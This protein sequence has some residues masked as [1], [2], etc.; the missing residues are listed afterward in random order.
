[1]DARGTILVVAL[2]LHAFPVGAQSV[3]LLL[4]PMSAFQKQAFKDALAKV[5]TMPE[6]LVRDQAS[7]FVAF[8]LM[9]RGDCPQAL[10][11]MTKYLVKVADPVAL[12]GLATGAL[13]GRDPLCMRWVATR[14]E[15]ALTKAPLTDP[16]RAELRIRGQT[17]LML[18]GQATRSYKM[19]A[20]NFSDLDTVPESA[21]MRE[22]E[23]EGLTVHIS[24]G[25]APRRRETLLI[26]RLWD[27]R[28]TPLQ[29]LLAKSLEKRAA[30]E[31]KFLTSTGWI[32]VALVLLG[33]GE[34]RSAER[35]LETTGVRYINGEGLVV[36][37][38]LR[39]GDIQHTVELIARGDWVTKGKTVSRLTESWPAAFI[40]YVEQPSM[41]GTDFNA[42][43]GLISYSEALDRAGFPE[44]AERA[45][46][47]ALK[48]P[49]GDH[50]GRG[51]QAQALARLGHLEAARD[52]VREAEQRPKIEDP[53]YV[54]LGVARG[55][56]L[57][58]NFDE[59]I[60][61]IEAAPARERDHILVDTLAV[62][63][64]IPSNVRDSLEQRLLRRLGSGQPLAVS[65]DAMVEFARAGL[66][67]ELLTGAISRM[68][69]GRKNARLVTQLADLARQSGHSANAIIIAG[70]AE[71]LLPDSPQADAELVA[72]ADLYWKLSSPDKATAISS[73]VSH[74]VGSIDALTR[75]FNP[76]RGENQPKLS[77]VTF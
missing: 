51:R 66:R 46:R 26:N 14:I 54:R 7:T 70:L 50:Y 33:A 21:S 43:L 68:E 5:S 58:G 3:S 15:T 37:A 73:R 72:L 40:P 1:M 69:R 38:A 62:V 17:M 39:Q 8:R 57:S 56:A 19:P 22:L 20:A 53:Y 35:L 24:L 75:A 48:I 41:F 60:M 12:G 44:A 45:A 63:G 23:L 55:A 61:A 13:T 52:L 30:V 29:L 59:A 31:P 67:P 9:M 11:I 65:A 77:F 74:Q 2:L 18:A 27:Y 64:S 16:Q 71:T 10:P 28:G 6:G 36:E 32:E 4:E 34:R 42:K 25:D 47:A 49:D 76:A